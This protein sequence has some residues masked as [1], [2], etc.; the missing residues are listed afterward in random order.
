MVLAVSTN[1]SVVNNTLSQN[2]DGVRLDEADGNR[3]HRNHL[4][5]HAFGIYLNAARGNT[6]EENVIDG[7]DVGIELTFSSDDNAVIRNRI[8]AQRAGIRETASGG[9][10][11]EGNEVA[12]TGDG[13]M[14][15]SPAVT[16]RDRE[17]V[18]SSPDPSTDR[19]GAN[20]AGLGYGST[21]ASLGILVVVGAA[22]AWRRFRRPRR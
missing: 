9:N 1:N 11:L 4:L 19:T 17:A 12:V 16:A 15:R 21:L 2:G 14:T 6:V 10:A 22:L 18:E 5:D 7:A 20:G 8:T 13:T 3:I